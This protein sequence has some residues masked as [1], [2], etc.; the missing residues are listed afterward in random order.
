MSQFNEVINTLYTTREGT[1]GCQ[2][3]LK[4]VQGLG[5]MQLHAT[6]QQTND[7][8]KDEV[9][10][11]IIKPLIRKL[12]EMG[13]KPGYTEEMW[14]DCLGHLASPSVYKG[15]GTMNSR[16]WRSEPLQG[17]GTQFWGAFVN[18]I[19]KEVNNTIRAACRMPKEKKQTSLFVDKHK[20]N[21]ERVVT[22]TFVEHWDRHAWQTEQQRTH[23][24]IDKSQ[25]VSEVAIQEDNV[26]RCPENQAVHMDYHIG[27][28]QRPHTSKSPN[29]IHS[30]TEQTLGFI[31]ETELG[32]NETH[33]SSKKFYL[34]GSE[35]HNLTST[36]IHPNNSRHSNMNIKF[37]E[38][39]LI[40]PQ[41]TRHSN[42]QQVYGNS[43]APV[44]EE[45][46]QHHKDAIDMRHSNTNVESKKTLMKTSV[47]LQ[48][49]S[50]KEYSPATVPKEPDKVNQWAENRGQAMGIVAVSKEKRDDKRTSSRGHPYEGNDKNRHSPE[51]NISE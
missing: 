11:Y 21:S 6:S 5:D 18:V 26:R 41:M 17:Y 24:F 27:M 16:L 39:M 36:G 23:T 1:K 13:L 40:S 29:M 46:R 12:Q 30:S 48:K 33:Y 15:D 34:T 43:Q 32:N 14:M 20:K 31:D 38:K 22:R 47:K 7:D 51:E 2:K 9:R 44:V 3:H 42:Q 50:T 25:K 28:P 37:R 45:T 8:K 35:E 10:E 19:S 49:Q 4:D